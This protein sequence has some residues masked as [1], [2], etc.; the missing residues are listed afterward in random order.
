MTDSGSHTVRER[1]LPAIAW[2]YPH[3]ELK[4]KDVFP[5]FTGGRNFTFQGNLMND[6]RTF[7]QTQMYPFVK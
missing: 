1:I 4:N 2:A 6:L 7:D 5:H 3:S